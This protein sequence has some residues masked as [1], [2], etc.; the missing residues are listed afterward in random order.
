MR[1]G[2]FA[3]INDALVIGS[4]GVDSDD[5]NYCLRV[6]N[7]SQQAFQDGE[8]SLNS[9]IFACADKTK[10]NSLP[11]GTSVL[12]WAM[13]NGSVFADVSGSKDPTANA[14][15]DLQLVEGTPPIFSIGF[16]TMSVDG[17]TPGGSP[18]RG[19]HVGGLTTSGS[20][21]ASGW[22]YGI[23]EDNRA[24]ALWFE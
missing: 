6:D 20:N 7:R 18:Q 21:W 16:E 9:V 19:D 11:N 14:D 12:Q 4:F 15:T 2:I 10:G 8:L 17:D 3:T 1:E 5:D 23:F 24:Q 13:D 22:T